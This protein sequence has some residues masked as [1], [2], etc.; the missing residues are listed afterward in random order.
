M[1][2]FAANRCMFMSQTGRRRHF[3]SSNR[4]TCRRLCQQTSSS[5]T[6][7][8]MRMF[9]LLYERK[10]PYAGRC[11]SEQSQRSDS[12]TWPAIA[13]SDE[14][15]LSADGGA[16]AGSCAIRLQSQKRG[17]CSR[18]G[19]GP[20]RISRVAHRAEYDADQQAKQASDCRRWPRDQH[21]EDTGRN[22]RRNSSPQSPSTQVPVP[23]QSPSVSH[24]HLNF[25]TA[26]CG[27]TGVMFPV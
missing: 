27:L 14:V 3:S 4:K 18:T 7:L 13:D 6:H 20:G 5:L 9:E 11:G 22:L 25:D 21:V 26:S 16:F 17:E 24:F 10:G 1:R 15:R 2:T 19:R 12:R 8:F 23:S